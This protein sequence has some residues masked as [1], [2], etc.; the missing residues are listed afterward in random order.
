MRTRAILR[1][2]SGLVGLIAVVVIAVAAVLAPVVA[3][4]DPF[5]QNLRASLG[6]AGRQH[7]MG[8]DDLGRDTFARVLF[9]A[10]VS[11]MIGAG[12]V[13]LG[14]LVGVPLGLASGYFGGTFDAVAMRIADLL[15][16]FPRILMAI[17]IVAVYGVGINS[18]LVAIAVPD[19]PIFARLARA[20]T[21]SI[22]QLDYVAAGRALG[23]SDT[24]IMARHVLPNLVGPVTVQ[25]TFSVAAAILIAG[26]LSFLGLGVRPPT[27][28]WGS[29]LAQ[30]R[31]YMR[32]APHLITYPGLAL[33]AT[34]LGI[35]LLGDALRQAYD[36]RF[37]GRL[38][39]A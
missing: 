16:A 19:I 30:A 4:H 26:G 7:W 35:N 20:S 1:S 17:L 14:L 38:G 8:T 3:R 9:G 34:V 2:K 37:R 15:L 10:R 23:A 27:P 31:T 24:R 22:I 33:A 32:T 21:L 29:M 11:L 39:G 6:P 5:E 36:P 18:L 12:A 28:E 13:G 25:A